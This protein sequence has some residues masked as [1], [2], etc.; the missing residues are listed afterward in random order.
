MMYKKK[1]V[2]NYMSFWYCR[3]KNRKGTETLRDLLLN[4]FMVLIL[5]RNF[6]KVIKTLYSPPPKIKK[7]NSAKM[8][9]P[10]E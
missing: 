10:I 5:F 2:W 8:S 6:E 4:L 9:I 3:D 1:I 7:K